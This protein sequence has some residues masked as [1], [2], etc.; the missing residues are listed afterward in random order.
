MEIT[1]TLDVHGDA[2]LLQPRS[3]GRVLTTSVGPSVLHPHVPPSGPGTGPEASS[4][5]A[6]RQSLPGFIVL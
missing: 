3:V 1:G 6:C 2:W 5:E 4:L